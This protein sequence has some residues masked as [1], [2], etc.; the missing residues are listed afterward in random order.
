MV[1]MEQ[2]KVQGVY[3]SKAVSVVTGHQIKSTVVHIKYSK[4]ERITLNV[5]V[6]SPQE[7][8]GETNKQTIGME[9]LINV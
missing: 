1:F 4:N 9:T 5:A 6:N 8:A 7:S 2:A 3:Q